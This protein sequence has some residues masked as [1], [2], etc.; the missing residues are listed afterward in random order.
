MWVASLREVCGGQANRSV[1]VC[2]NTQKCVPV[3]VST[4]NCVCTIIKTKMQFNAEHYSTSFANRSSLPQV[5]S[6]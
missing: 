3:C 6:S 4:Q 2:V 1:S 5:L